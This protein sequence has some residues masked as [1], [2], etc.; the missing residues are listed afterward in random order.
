[1]P[2]APA[3]RS[4]RQKGWYPLLMTSSGSM[5]PP[6]GHSPLQRLLG[7]IQ[8]PSASP[9]ADHRDAADAA[10]AAI[11]KAGVANPQRFFAVLAEE[12]SLNESSDVIWALGSIKNSLAIPVLTAA[13]RSRSAHIRWA[14]ANSLASYHEE[15]ALFALLAAL[16]DRAP[17]VRHVVI[18]ALGQHGDR[19]AVEP[20]RAALARPANRKSP[21]TQKLLIQALAQLGET[22]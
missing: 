10:G 7:D 6:P 14:A 4:M 1:M 16:G 2:A 5:S 22:E 12:T 20:L 15:T 8:V 3:D 13:L 19:R 9:G 21:Y 11:V 17:T 18:E